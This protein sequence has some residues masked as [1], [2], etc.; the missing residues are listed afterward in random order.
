MDSV[1]DGAT[2]LLDEPHLGLLL[3]DTLELADS[4]LVGTSSGDTFAATAEDHVEVHTEDTGAG[5]I[6]D[7]EVNVFVDTEA[8]VACYNN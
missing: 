8:E 5:V 6:L 7:A 1:E 3:G 2:T 4:G